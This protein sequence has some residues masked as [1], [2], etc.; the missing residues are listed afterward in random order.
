M[1][2]EDMI[3]FNSLKKEIE[4]SRHGR[5]YIKTTGVLKSSKPLKNDKLPNIELIT[6]IKEKFK[7]NFFTPA[8]STIVSKEYPDDIIL[9][10]S[11]DNK[12]SNNSSSKNKIRVDMD[13]IFTI[14]REVKITKEEIKGNKILSLLL[15]TQ[16]IDR[17][18]L[19][20]LRNNKRVYIAGDAVLDGDG[21]LIMHP[22]TSVVNPKGFYIS[23][24]HHKIIENELSNHSDTYMIAGTIL[25]GIGLATLA[26]I[27][28]R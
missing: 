22:L 14:E 23:T 6:I 16:Q 11:S 9:D 28:L 19:E 17:T 20:Y 15:G 3:D 21:I 26:A 12:E 5:V 27:K 7:S 13:D 24:K 8:I 4:K 10:I 25:G 18:S 2:N 1:K